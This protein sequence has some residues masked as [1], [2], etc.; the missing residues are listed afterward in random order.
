MDIHI[1]T[2]NDYDAFKK[3]I[4]QILEEVEITRLELLEPT[5]QEQDDVTKVIKEFIKKKIV[6]YMA[7]ML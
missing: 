6:K 3:D 5:K 4:P 2:E 7:D 1:Y